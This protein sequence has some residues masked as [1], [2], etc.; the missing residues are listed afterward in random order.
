M[1]YEQIAVE[2]KDMGYGTR[3][4]VYNDLKLAREQA[5]RDTAENLEA[6]RDLTN[7]RYESLLNA[8]WAAA[9]AGDEKSSK[10]VLQILAQQA[11]LNGTNAPKDIRLQLE[12]RNDMEALLVTE[13]V[14]A[15]FDAAGLPPEMRMAAL[16]AA[17]RRLA[18]VD[19]SVVAGEIIQ[20]GSED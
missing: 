15:A 5:N 13:A 20:A 1:T 18:E 7:A 14:L 11:T 6:L 4:D 16:E 12:R 9:R 8:H 17:Q 3:A 19:D 10:I 2:L